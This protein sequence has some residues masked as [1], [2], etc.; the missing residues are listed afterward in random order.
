MNISTMTEKEVA[1]AFI[2]ARIDY[3]GKIDAEG[4][5]DQF[6]K[7]AANELGDLLNK[8]R[9]IDVVEYADYMHRVMVAI[10]ARRAVLAGTEYYKR[11]AAR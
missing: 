6:S 4:M 2:Q 5:L 3:L 9:L 11:R 10:Q 1:L 7:W 8:R